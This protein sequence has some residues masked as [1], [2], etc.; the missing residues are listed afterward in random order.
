MDGRGHGA[1]WSEGPHLYQRDDQ[2]YLLTAEGGTSRHHSLAIARADVP[3]GPFVGAP[4]NP[5]FTHR[6]LGR[7]YPV[8]AVGHG[9]LVDDPSG[10]S[11][12][13]C[14]GVRQGDG[15]D[16]LGRE[17]FL[18]DV[19][20]GTAG[21]CSR[22]AGGVLDVH[23]SHPELVGEYRPLSQ[24]IDPRITVR[25]Q[26][27]E[28]GAEDLAGGILRLPAGTALDDTLP[29]YVAHRLTCR[30]ARAAM[31]ICRAD[32]GVRAGV[33]LRYSSTAWARVTVGEGTFRVEVRTRGV[34]PFVVQR[35]VQG[36][37]GEIVVDIRTPYATFR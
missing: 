16:H 18:V 20:W 27:C 10:N 9:D 33:G 25:R 6:H 21:R 37:D 3:T 15:S 12:C 5:I 26:I 31:R 35:P 34:E 1:R 8:L 4:T 17:T 24:P 29:A 28:L 22:S 11:W 32:P 14:L 7:G 36:S 23:P 30:D 19:A 2:V 13:L